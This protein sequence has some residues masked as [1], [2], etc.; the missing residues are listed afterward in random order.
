MVGAQDGSGRSPVSIVRATTR[1]TSG[2]EVTKKLINAASAF[3]TL[4]EGTFGPQ[5]LDKMLYKTNGETAITNDGAKII[6]ELLVKHPSAKAFV[7]LADAQELACGNGVTTAVLFASSL[8]KEAGLLLEKRLHPLVVVSGYQQ[9]LE[10]CAYFFEQ[11]SHTSDDV[12]STLSSILKTSLNGTMA[13][14]EQDHLSELLLDSIRLVDL[15]HHPRTGY[16]DIR[17]TKRRVGGISDTRLI[18]G[19]IID[20]NLPLDG[21]KRDIKNGRV[22][23]LTCPLEYERTTRDAEIQI[24]STEQYSSFIQSKKAI[25]QRKMDRIRSSKA[26]LI[27]C[28]E[29]IDTS[30]LHE[31]SKEGIVLF[32]NIEDALLK[33][34]AQACT[35][36][37]IDHLDDL[38][39]AS[40]GLIEQYSIETTESAEGR[41]ERILLNIGISS[42]IA[43][44]DVGGDGGEAT[45]EVVRNLY[46]ALRSAAVFFEYPKYVYG[47]GAIFTGA[48]L[49]L[50]QWAERTSTRERLAIEA[51]AR[52]LERIPSS[53]AGNAGKNKLDTILELRSTHRDAQHDYGVGIDGSLQS[54]KNVIDPSYV[55]W[56]AIELAC[57]TAT[58]LL[59]V[60]QVISSRGD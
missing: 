31:L 50:R 58:G 32:G 36:D 34:I 8:L 49:H 57:E 51:F 52:S 26:S 40:C 2:P 29:T 22:A 23:C 9:A 3:G 28:S 53:L 45:E 42:R 41:H 13:S 25:L 21:Q 12:W 46:D 4:M 48:A 15:Q 60:D 1:I 54:M 43:T 18:Q 5:G 55:V 19:I 6:A 30:I 37:L 39:E 47:G 44:I 10:E 24:T 14:T 33:D 7:Q 35:S 20:Q 59:R 17:M 27:F 56:H 38:D 11:H 16:E